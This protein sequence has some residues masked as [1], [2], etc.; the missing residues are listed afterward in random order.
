MKLIR[1]IELSFFLVLALSLSNGLT[2]AQFIGFEIQNRSGRTTFEFEKVNNLVVVPVMLN[3]KLPLNFILDTGVRTTI[4]TDRDISD[5]VSISYDRAVTIAG[6]GHIRE[7]KA[8][9]ASNVSLSMPGISGRGQSLIVL[10]EDYLELGSHLGMHVHGIIG[11]EFF[12]HFVVR[13][14]YDRKLIT[15]YDPEV[16]RVPRR[17]DAIPFSVEQGRPYINSSVIQQDE[18]RVDTKLLIDSGASHGL[19]LETDTDENISLPGENLRTII[20]WG[21]GGELAGCLGRIKA[22]KINDFKFRDVLV[23][24]ADDYSNPEV[25]RVTGRNGSIGGD[26]L[27]RFTVIFDYPDS[28]LYLRKNRTF[29]YPFEFNL[30]GIDLVAAGPGFGSFRIINVIEGSPAYEA[31]LKSG[32]LILVVNGKF[33]S[34]VTLSEINTLLRSRS[35]AKIN[36]TINRDTEIIRVSF[37]LRRMI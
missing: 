9:L 12:N 3:N 14:D 37:R 11:Y 21:L 19:L 25:T 15:V 7:L 23:S 4:L 16:F 30:G 31:G 8:Y 32:D 5:L 33:S 1:R 22:L 18:T 26:V 2:Y 28:M 34:D 13:I 35:G 20:G 24:F 10:E 17:F 29:R 27:S 6:A 36:M